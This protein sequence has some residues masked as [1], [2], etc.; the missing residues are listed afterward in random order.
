MP[1]C[2]DIQGL[3]IKTLSVTDYVEEENEM[4]PQGDL[5]ISSFM[6][7]KPDCGNRNSYPTEEEIQAE[8]VYCKIQPKVC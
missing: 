4:D 6:T 2:L 7:K 3:M 5:N 8:P 1:I